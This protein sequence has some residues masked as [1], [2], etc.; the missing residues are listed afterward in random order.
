MRVCAAQR[1]S[2]FEAPDLGR[3]ERGIIFRTYESSSFVSSH[4]TFFIQGQIAF[5]NTVQCINK[6]TV[7]L[8][9]GIKNWPISRTGYQF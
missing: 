1:G 5:K 3:L 7:V 2:D 4:F 8:E 9:R 6:Q